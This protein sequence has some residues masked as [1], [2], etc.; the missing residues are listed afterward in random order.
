M[1]RPPSLGYAL[2]SLVMQVTALLISDNALSRHG[3]T[4]GVRTQFCIRSATF[5]CSLYVIYIF[6]S[7]YIITRTSQLR[8]WCGAGTVLGSR[9]HSSKG[10]RGA[11][12][13]LMAKGY[14]NYE[15]SERVRTAK[16][17]SS[18]FRRMHN[19]VRKKAL[20]CS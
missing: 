18:R 7:C 1:V 15:Q 19:S 11:G 13:G 12:S 8:S 17:N 16:H 4:R 14:T 10:Q 9:W 2:P 6:H 5:N 3:H 20:D